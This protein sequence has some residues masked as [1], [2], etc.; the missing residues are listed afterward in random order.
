MLDGG[1][2]GVASNGSVS[3]S[4]A[5][6]H[7]RNV[8]A[9]E[10]LLKSGSGTKAVGGS[11]VDFFTF[12]GDGAVG[13]PTVL[14]LDFDILTLKHASCFSPRPVNFAVRPA[15]IPSGGLSGRG[16][17]VYLGAGQATGV[18]SIGGS[19]SL[20][21]GGVSILSGQ[22]RVA[23]GGVAIA[24]NAG[25]GDAASGGSRSDRGPRTGRRRSTVSANTPFR[26]RR[27]FSLNTPPA[28]TAHASICSSR[29]VFA[30]SD[31]FARDDGGIDDRH[32]LSGGRRLRAR[33]GRRRRHPRQTEYRSRHRRASSAG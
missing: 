6:T 33:T 22:G 29:F 17:D 13:E 32:P 23:T 28:P 4:A 14:D 1:R 20:A 27:R 16:G 2:F 8:P 10:I 30:R 11:G 9:S 19:V 26:A 21:V 18:G 3:I 24:S 31:G 15:A 5:D 12:A 25:V 7:G